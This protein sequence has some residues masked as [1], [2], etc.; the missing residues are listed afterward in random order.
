MVIFNAW[1]DFSENIGEGGGE[2]WICM[3]SHFRNSYSIWMGTRFCPTF[4]LLSLFSHVW[5]NINFRLAKKAVFCFTGQQLFVVKQLER[6]EAWGYPSLLVPHSIFRNT[7]FF[8]LIFINEMFPLK[9]E[10]VSEEIK[11]AVCYFPRKAC[12]L[13]KN[14]KTSCQTIIFNGTSK[15]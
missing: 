12:G 3:K 15:I 7:C 13:Q 9:T 6:T 4:C 1:G 11:C 8:T 2:W 14:C 5:Q 10:I